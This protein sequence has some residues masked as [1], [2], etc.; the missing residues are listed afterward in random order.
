MNPNE[1]RFAA[2]AMLL[3]LAKWM[4]LLGYDCLADEALF[5]RGLAERAVA[6]RRWIL[7]RNR[8][9][10]GD[11]PKAL[12]ERADIFRVTAEELPGQLREVAERFS[13]DASAFLFTRCLVCNEPVAPVAKRDLRAAVPPAVWEREERF[14]QC[15][16][17]GR[18]YW[19]GSHVRDSARRLEAWLGGS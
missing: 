18:V 12:L 5:G 10:A 9:W 4:R 19:Q 13:L 15:A 6:D 14:W 1:V 2:D 17:C 16:R 11:L 8:R 3:S 7:T